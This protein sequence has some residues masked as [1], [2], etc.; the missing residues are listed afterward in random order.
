MG[1]RGY[2]MAGISEAVTTG[3]QP[4][5]TVGDLASFTLIVGGF[6]AAVITITVCIQVLRGKDMPQGFW[7]IFSVVIGFYFG[8]F[9]Q[10]MVG[11]LR[12]GQSAV[13]FGEVTVFALVVGGLVACARR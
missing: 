9:A 13:T 5:V 3:G 11:G 2:S 10:S 12:G 1:V 4:P 6:I 7:N 8:T